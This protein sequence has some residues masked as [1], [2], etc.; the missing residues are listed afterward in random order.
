ML[1]EFMIN[2]E[3]SGKLNRL[4]RN[5]TRRRKPGLQGFDRRETC[6][7]RCEDFYWFFG[8]FENRRGGRIE[9]I[10]LLTN[11]I[12]GQELFFGYFLA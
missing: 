1:M 5:H 8:M 7:T 9:N 6:D 11:D 10:F 4:R 3:K 2:V 12:D